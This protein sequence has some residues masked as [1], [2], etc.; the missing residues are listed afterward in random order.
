MVDW[1]LFSTIKICTSLN[2]RNL[3]THPRPAFSQ[4]RTTLLPP[5][6]AGVPLPLSQIQY[7]TTDYDP[8]YASDS[9]ALLCK[10]LCSRPFLFFPPAVAISFSISAI[11]PK[12]KAPS[13]LPLIYLPALPNTEAMVT[14]NTAPVFQDRVKKSQV[15]F[16]R[17]LGTLMTLITVVQG[18]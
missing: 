3:I 8:R 1:G 16:F 9:L 17:R 14:N 11:L 2:H 18:G 10:D 5:P 12:A 7:P 13:F 6:T 15:A 4:T